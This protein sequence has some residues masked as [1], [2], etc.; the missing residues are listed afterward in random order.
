MYFG[1]ENECVSQRK[2]HD[3]EM[4]ATACTQ[5]PTARSLAKPDFSQ[6]EFVCR[7][8]GVISLTTH[9]IVCALLLLLACGYE[10]TCKK[11]D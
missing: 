7:L 4:T 2:K 5:I 9:K 10:C 3:E 6:W 11:W 8:L 1:N